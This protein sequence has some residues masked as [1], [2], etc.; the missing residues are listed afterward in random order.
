M[1][2]P[3]TVEGQLYPGLDKLEFDQGHVTNNQPITVLVM[4]SETLGI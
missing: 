4:L 3:L 1:G 2:V